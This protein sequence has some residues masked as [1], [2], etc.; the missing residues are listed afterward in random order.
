[1]LHLLRIATRQ[2]ITC[3]HLQIIIIV[4]RVYY[5]VAS[6]AVCFCCIGMQ[7]IDIQS[8]ANHNRC[9]CCVCKIIQSLA[10]ICIAPVATVVSVAYVR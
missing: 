2:D 6:V 8:L 1:M 10:N 9:N 7:A 5:I 3:N 4:Y